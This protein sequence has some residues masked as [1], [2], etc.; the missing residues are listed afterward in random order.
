MN[1]VIEGTEHYEGAATMESVPVDASAPPD[2]P[3]G[4]DASTIP[5]EHLKNLLS[6]Q[7]EYYFSR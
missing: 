1:G 6:A 3:S 7:L 2:S 5:L 4:S